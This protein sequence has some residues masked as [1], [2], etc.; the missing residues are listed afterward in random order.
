MPRVS[1]APDDH[2]CEVT[3]T[4]IGVSIRALVDCAGLVKE[5]GVSLM[6]ER[7]AVDH[8]LLNAGSSPISIAPWAITQFRLGGIALVPLGSTGPG[9]GSEAD[10]SLVV[11]PYTSLADRRLSMLDSAAVV[12]AVAGPPF[13]IGSGPNP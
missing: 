2:R 12:E 5:I 11:W 7:L 10:R 13:K 1:Y 3:Q 9:S 4:T 6:D 8:R